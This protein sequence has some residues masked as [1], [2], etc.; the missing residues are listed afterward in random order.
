MDRISLEVTL[1]ERARRDG[2]M[3]SNMVFFPKR[4]SLLAGCVVQRLSSP[5]CDIE[6]TGGHGATTSSTRPQP[7]FNATSDYYKDDDSFS[8]IRSINSGVCISSGYSAGFFSCCFPWDKCLP[9]GLCRA[10]ESSTYY[11][12]LCTDQ[13]LQDKSCQKG[14]SKSTPH[15]AG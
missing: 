3:V 10:T 12:A 2:Y 4:I 15:H 7:W 9:D 1:R 6:A 5:Y 13:T 14:C 11:T 8:L